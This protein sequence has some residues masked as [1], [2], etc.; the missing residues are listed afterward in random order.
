MSQK[1]AAFDTQGNISA[2]YDD[3]DSP[4]PAAVS[5]VLKI[6]DAQ[7]QT[8]I[9]T[10]GYTVKS[11]ALVAPAS[12]TTAQIA[13]QQAAAA[14]SAY[15]AGAKAAL[16][17]SDVTIL[18]CYEHAV[19]TPAAWSTY[20]GALRAIISAASGDPTQPLPTRPAYPAGT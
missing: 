11:G 15:Q 20:R 10:P 12:P 18:R 17:A 19:A 6:T 1:F 16:D 7:W 8:C 4:V 5:N 2:F 3:V 13:A 14:W 9:S